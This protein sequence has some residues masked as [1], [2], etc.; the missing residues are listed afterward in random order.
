MYPSLTFLPLMFDAAKAV[1]TGFDFAIGSI[2]SLGNGI[3]RWNVYDSG[4]NNVDGLTTNGNAC[5]EAG[6]FGC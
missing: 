5:F 4:C 2:A 6:M 1:C 3:N